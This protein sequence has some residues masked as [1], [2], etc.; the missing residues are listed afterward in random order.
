[1]ATNMREYI[2][3]D[4]LVIRVEMASKCFKVSISNKCMIAVL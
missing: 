3:S 2:I 1:M 4:K